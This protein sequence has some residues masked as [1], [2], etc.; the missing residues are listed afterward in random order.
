MSDYILD[1]IWIIMTLA[2]SLTNR[3]E[4][5]QWTLRALTAVGVVS[6]VTKV[7]KKNYFE[8]ENSN[9]T[10]NE[11]VFAKKSIPLDQI[12]KVQIKASPFSSSKIILKDKKIVK[13]SDSQVNDRKLKDFM[14]SLNISVE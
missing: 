12:E 4:F 9:L 1:I 5:G 11:S 2:Y 10:I 13:Y 3:P 6:L 8:I 14:A 7:H